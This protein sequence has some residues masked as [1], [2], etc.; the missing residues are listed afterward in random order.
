MILRRSS[1]AS[2]LN[3]ILAAGDVAIVAGALTAA[4]QLRR[5]FPLPWTRGLLP[6]EKFELDAVNVSVVAGSLLLA[7]LLSGFYGSRRSV[8]HRPFILAA[9][10]IQIAAVAI[11]TIAL[12]RTFPRTV[13]AMMG[14]FELV[15]LPLWRRIVVRL[16]P[17]R[18]GSVIVVGDGDRLGVFLDLLSRRD[19][20]R[21][22]IAGV[23]SDVCPQ[24]LALPYLGSLANPN[25]IDR[26]R[27]VDEVLC[28]T[29][30]SAARLE[31]LRLRE[32]RG[33]LVFPTEGDALLASADLAWIADQPL[34]EVRVRSAFGVG[35]VAKRTFDIVGSLILGV[36]TLPIA[37]AA[38]VAVFLDDGVPIVLSQR[39]LGASG[40]TIS[41]LK[42]RTMRRSTVQSDAPIIDDDPRVS[43]V[44]RWLRRYRVDELP[45]VLNI[46]R[47]EMSLVGPR[48]EMPDVAAR[49]ATDVAGFGLRTLVKP[50]LAGL[51]QVS[52]EYDTP[53]TVKLRYDLTYITNWSL[54]LDARILFSTISTVLSGRGV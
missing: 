12:E 44:G 49:L 52:S 42:F 32:A 40:R 45:Q 13:L 43:R 41:I 4:V 35:A 8:R 48:P 28:A 36:A 26:I 22:E 15:L 31:L 3:T 34:I 25:V 10:V 51:A 7:L 11:L 29:E 33:F 46:L 50:G 6:A 23:V 24:G 30:S 18:R 9:V 14:G 19:D 5:N 39:R 16:L 53:A 54:S 20:P 2:L 47:G 21:V 38:A 17:L 27:E 37:I 1:G